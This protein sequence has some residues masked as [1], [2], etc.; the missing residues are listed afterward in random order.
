MQRRRVAHVL[1]LVVALGLFSSQVAPVSAGPTPFDSPLPVPALPAG[2]TLPEPI[3]TVL[4]IASPSAECLANPGGDRT[5][6]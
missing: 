2:A 6:L 4:A 3:V 5:Y 1:D